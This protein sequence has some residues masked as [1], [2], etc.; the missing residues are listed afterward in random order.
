ME[1]RAVGHAGV[2]GREVLVGGGVDEVEQRADERG[3]LL[4]GQ[5]RAVAEH[6]DEPDLR[7]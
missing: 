1:R 7:A 6:L 2:H 3:G 5:H 4:G